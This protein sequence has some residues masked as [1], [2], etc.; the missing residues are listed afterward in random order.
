MISLK[1]AMFWEK[2]GEKIR[3]TLCHNNCLIG[4]GRLGYCRV[5]ENR[6]GILYSTAYGK[7]S[8]ISSDPV[9]K[10]PFFN[11]Y[12]GTYIWSYGTVGCTFRCDYCQ[13]YTISQV[14]AESQRLVD[15]RV[16]DVVRGAK[17][18]VCKGVAWTYNEPTVWYEFTYDAS[19][20]AK[21]AGLYTAYV[22]NGYIKEEP[23]RKIAPYI[24][25][26]NVDVKTF[27][28]ENM[29]KMSKTKLKH[30]LNFCKLV[31]ELGKHLEISY[32]VAMTHSDSPEQIKDF[33]NWVVS[34]LGKETPIHFLRCRPVYKFFERETPTKVLT[35]T[36]D[37]AIESGLDYVYLGNIRHGKWDSTYCPNC[38]KAII[39]RKGYHLKK[40]YKDNKCIYCGEM[41]GV[42]D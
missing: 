10:K 24:D 8:S 9:E 30:V 22:T 34:D 28:K 4:N 20:L 21:K 7:A 35:N 14:G 37:I 33:C 41:V 17:S 12:P 16:E 1:E 32:L 23:F 3:C 13:N 42:V 25:A 18:H 2:E 15:V 11:F 40:F 38:K 29:K 26:F 5:R 6:D 39:D 36:Y 31:K 27:R 19:I